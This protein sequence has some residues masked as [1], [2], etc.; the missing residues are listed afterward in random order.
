VMVTDHPWVLEVTGPKPAMLSRL[1]LATLLFG[2]AVAALLAGFVRMLT[3]QAT[4]DGERLAWF[5]EQNA[6]RDSLTRELNHRVKN[7]L[8]NVLSIVALTR[9]RAQSVDEFAEGLDGRIRALSA[10]HD[11]LTH[12]DWGSTPVR[13]VIET[14]LAPYAREEGPVIAIDG[15]SIELAPKDALSLGLA[16]HELATNAAK[17]GALGLT[18]GRLDVRWGEVEEGRVR[19]AWTESGGPPVPQERKRGFGTD[20]IER[21]VAHELQSP[22]D[23]RFDPEGVR[24]TLVVPVRPPSIFTLRGMPEAPGQGT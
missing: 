7:T 10:T 6:I 3:R 17:Y 4:E 11:L 12:S 15:P 21:I 19:I 13:A 2:L 24:C 18:A 8:A 1:S 9:R 20:L 5:E 16:I 23:L 22:V 14:E